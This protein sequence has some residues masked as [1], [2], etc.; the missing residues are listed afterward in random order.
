MKMFQREK[1]NLVETRLYNRKHMTK[2]AR[3]NEERMPGDFNTH[4]IHRR[5]VNQCEGE[6]V[7]YLKSFLFPLQK[8]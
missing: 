4:L 1:R 6:R 8:T 5:Q 2:S 7:I 3:M